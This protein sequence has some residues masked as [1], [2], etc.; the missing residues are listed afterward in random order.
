MPT[1]EL[2]QLAYELYAHVPGEFVAARNSRAARLRRDGQRELAGQVSRLPK[3]SVA[4]WAVGAVVRARPGE[5]DALGELGAELRVAQSMANPAELR[6]LSRRRRERAAAATEAAVRLAEEREVAVSA[7]ARD[8]VMSIWQAVVID[9]DA[10][11]GV[12]SGLPVRAIEPGEEVA[13]AVAVPEVIANVAARG[14]EPAVGPER[15]GRG[16]AGRSTE[17]GGEAARGGGEAGGDR[18][19]AD[20]PGSEVPAARAAETGDAGESPATRRPS[21]AQAREIRRLR[22]A[23]KAGERAVT[24][25][26]QELDAAST[27]HSRLEAEG[28]HLAARLDELQRELAELEERAEDVEEARAGAE[29]EVEDAEER[30]RAAEEELTELRKQLADLEG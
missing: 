18:G 21:A 13:A 17:D 10:E 23:V 20:G 15:D 2:A 7:A 26:A 27:E 24:L 6:A 14:A 1:A 12:R 28:L 29:E 4:A 19:A 8:Q 11:R 25:A 30:H 9:P 22:R 5:V 16:V 3:A